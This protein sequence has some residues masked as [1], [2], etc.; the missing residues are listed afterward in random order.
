MKKY[1]PKKNT[2]AKKVIFD[3]SDKKNCL[4]HYR[5]LKFYVRHGMIVDKTGEI[6]SF[7]QNKLLEKYENFIT[8]NRSK[9]ENEFEK[10]FYKL[11]NKAIYGKT[12]EIV[13][14]CLRIKIF[15][16]DDTKKIY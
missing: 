16:K 12:M 14:N 10:D 6:I 3:W 11:L 2:K 13:R 15:Q 1:K 4:I 7:K 9:A 8:Q 5:M